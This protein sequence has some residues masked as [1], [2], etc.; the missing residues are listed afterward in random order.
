MIDRVL[1]KRL[2]EPFNLWMEHIALL[3]GL[4]LN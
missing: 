4:A 1:T 3:R 2:K